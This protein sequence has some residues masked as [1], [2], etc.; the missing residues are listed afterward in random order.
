MFHTPAHKQTDA[1]KAPAQIINA[2]A[3]S[4]ELRMEAAVAA[5][6]DAMRYHGLD[7]T[8]ARSRIAKQFDVGTGAL[9]NALVE[10]NE[11]LNRVA[12]NDDSFARRYAGARS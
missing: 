12:G 9:H 10:A 2:T 4:P 1:D 7:W 8:E 3:A 5:L 6:R 11:A